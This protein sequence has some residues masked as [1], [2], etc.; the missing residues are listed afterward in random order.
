MIRIALA[1]VLLATPVLAETYHV[2]PSCST[3]AKL[4]G[5]PDTLTH[6][7]AVRARDALERFSWVF[8]TRRCRDAVRKQWKL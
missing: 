8:G 6:D 5:V 2:P 3:L 7:E 4:Y 1:L